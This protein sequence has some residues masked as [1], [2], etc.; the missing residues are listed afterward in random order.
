VWLSFN[1][2]TFDDFMKG[3]SDHSELDQSANIENYSNLSDQTANSE[4]NLK[5]ISTVLDFELLQLG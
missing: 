5:K 1:A 3:Q 4:P 2:A